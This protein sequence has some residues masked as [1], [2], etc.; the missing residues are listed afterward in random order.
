MLLREVMGP[1]AS[2]H[3]SST[4]REIARPYVLASA[5]VFF[6]VSLCTLVEPLLPSVPRWPIGALNL[7]SAVLLAVS[8]LLAVAAPFSLAHTRYSTAIACAACAVF[9]E[10]VGNDIFFYNSVL[11]PRLVFIL[12]PS[13]LVAFVPVHR[14]H[15]AARAFYLVLEPITAVSLG[16]VLTLPIL[17]SWHS[18]DPDHYF[19]Y[20]WWFGAPAMIGG[21]PALV[22]PWSR[23]P[24]TSAAA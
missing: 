20:L 8:L 4:S 12:I 13:L 17:K 11:L 1:D 21:I 18:A 7:L 9:Y 23:S 10:P 6:V 3:L 2:R 14:F 24:A 19:Y 5:A 22:R 15:P 16:V